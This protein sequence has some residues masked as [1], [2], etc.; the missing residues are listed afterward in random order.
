VSLASQAEQEDPALIPCTG[1]P[2]FPLE[3]KLDIRLHHARN[4][5]SQLFTIQ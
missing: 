4:I 3:Q 2:I 1:I 5:S